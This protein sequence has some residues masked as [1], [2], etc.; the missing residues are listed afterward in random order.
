MLRTQALNI[1]FRNTTNN[2]VAGQEARLVLSRGAGN[3]LYTQ[4]LPRRGQLWEATFEPDLTPSVYLENF[5]C[6]RHGP[7]RW[8]HLSLPVS[9]DAESLTVKADA[10][11]LI[12]FML[13]VS[14]QPH[15]LGL[16][17]Q[18]KSGLVNV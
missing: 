17:E 1:L 2:S 18:G 3:Q 13:S 11:L 9:P 16:C 7:E 6:T 12:F 15:T 8:Q 4:V 10:A 5:H 14:G